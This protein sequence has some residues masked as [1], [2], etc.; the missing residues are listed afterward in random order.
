MPTKA[1]LELLGCL[2]HTASSDPED[3]AIAGVLLHT[4]RGERGLE[5]GRTDLLAGTSCNR[6]AVGHS[7]VEAYG[8]L[9][10][11]TLWRIDD[12][13]TVQA[14]LRPKVKD[15]KLHG[16]E[17]RLSEGTVVVRERDR[18]DTL[19]D[20]PHDGGLRLEFDD[21]PIGEFPRSA[22]SLLS[23]VPTRRSLTDVDGRVLPALPRSD[24]AAAALGPFVKVAGLLKTP[25]EVYRYHQRLP[26]LVQIGTTYRG[27]VTTSRWDDDT[28]TDGEAP[29][30][31]VYAPDLPP[32]ERPATVEIL[33]TGSGL[34]TTQ[35]TVDDGA[36][37][38]DVPLPG[39]DDEDASE[40]PD[41][42]LLCHAA[43]LVV[44]AQMA[45]GSMLQ[46]K[47]R[48]GHAKASALL[49]MLEQ[50]GLVGPADGTRAR[51]VLVVVDELPRVLDTIRGRAAQDGE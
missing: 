16:V 28:P 29:S 10:R 45:S 31:E 33:R 42:G 34:H 1:L 19:F 18:D 51:E 3:G 24:I 30:S 35:S 20:D 23:T 12:V 25:L 22:W 27:A 39:M 43:E 47:L 13:R 46:R 8:Q 44:T 17:I 37:A 2:V 5:P 4:A 7:Y 49:N 38:D 15:N 6:L 26:I 11:P 40:D 21:G 50:R 36:A 32:V 48:I 9:H 41:L 14:A